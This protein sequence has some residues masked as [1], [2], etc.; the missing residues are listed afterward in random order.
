MKTGSRRA[1]S[2]LLGFTP[3]V[4]A[5]NEMQTVSRRGRHVGDVG[6]GY[7]DVECQ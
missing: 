4:S 3:F 5:T 6:E 1:F 7:C 2:L